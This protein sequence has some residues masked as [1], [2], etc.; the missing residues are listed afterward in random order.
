MSWSSADPL[1]AF[2]MA[3]NALNAIAATGGDL[4]AKSARVGWAGV[5]AAYR[6]ARVALGLDA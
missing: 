4:P 1:A 5:E 2:N 6:A 3:V